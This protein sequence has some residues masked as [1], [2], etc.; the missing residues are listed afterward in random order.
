MPFKRIYTGY[1]TNYVG[2]DP[3]GYDPVLRDFHLVLW[4]KCLPNGGVFYLTTDESRPYRLHHDSKLGKFV[5]SSDSIIHTYSRVK[6]GPMPGIVDQIP[7]EGVAAFFDLACSIGGYIVF[8]ANM[9]NGKKTINQCR[10]THGAIRDRFDLTLECIRRWYSGEKSPM[11]D[12][13]DRHADFFGLFDNFKGY[14]DYFLLQDL[15]RENGRVRFWLH[16]EDFGVT[17]PLPQDKE[18]YM[19]YM[20]NA[21]DFVVARN[22]RIKTYLVPGFED[23]GRWSVDF[24]FY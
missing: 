18:E 21:S 10:S 24:I 17:D 19:E 22:R 12:C 8:P 13:L 20:R 16:F 1:R 23:T 6:N 14:V 9:V 2:K 11:S 3:D 5:L 15:V 4:S 7:R